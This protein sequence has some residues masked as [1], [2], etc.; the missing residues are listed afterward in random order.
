MDTP[1]YSPT[2]STSGGASLTTITAVAQQQLNDAKG[3]VERLLGFRR[4]YDSRR[5]ELYRHYIGRPIERFFPDK[6]TKRASVFVPYPFSNVEQVR[7]T[8]M[9]A[10][11]AQDPC[12]E[13]LPRG[14]KDSLSA[15][16]MQRVL[17]LKLVQKAQLFDVMLDFTGGLAVYGFGALDVGWDWD[18]DIVASMQVRPIMNPDGSSVLHPVTNEPAL[19]R[20]MVRNKVPRMRPKLTAID[21]YD[22]LVD[23]DGAF[24]AKLFDKTFPQMVREHLTAKS[25]GVTLYDE[26][27]LGKIDVQLG[28]GKNR[29]H[30]LIHIAELWDAVNGTCTSLTIPEDPSSLSYKDKRY[31]N[32]AQ[33]YQ[34]FR[35]DTASTV[36]SMLLS[37]AY[38]NPYNHCRIPIL[39]MSFTKLPGEIFGLGV[40][41]PAF[42]LNESL[43]SSMGMIKDNW[44][45]GVNQRLVVSDSRDIDFDSLQGNNVPGGII[46]AQGDAT[47]AVFPLPVHAPSAGDYSILGIERQMIETV[48]GKGDFYS[49]GVGSSGGNDT[50]SGISSVIQEASKRDVN[51]VRQ[52]ETQIMEPAFQLSASNC[53]QFL[54]DDIEVRIT[55]EQ[56]AIGKVNSQFVRI[57]PEDILGSFDYKFHGSTYMQNVMIQ[58]RN[59]LTLA[60]VIASNPG[61]AQYIKPREAL[62]ELARVHQISYPGRF[63]KTEEEVAQEQEAAQQQAMQQQF[64]MAVAMKNA[65]ISPEHLRANASMQAKAAEEGSSPNTTVPQPPSD[66]TAGAARSRGQALGGNGVSRGGAHGKNK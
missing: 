42:S 43:N 54:T 57:A 4:P 19:Q 25:M 46:V 59:M 40:I 30:A 45:M 50:A 14:E 37:P 52:I 62:I 53:Q 1:V 26:D 21:I 60:N 41:E 3:I 47:T 11:F 12:F 55:D 61:M 58:Q 38:D 66:S 16:A 18:Y 33:N 23:P 48:A 7:A 39:H 44:N 27:A 15:L 35:R 65:G 31:A 20:Q 24:V 10:L 32:R 64:Q 63:I 28:R 51:V 17:D 6:K 22:L 9:N 49:R 29:D 5:D 13:A 8:I 2:A 56:P 34:T 36:E